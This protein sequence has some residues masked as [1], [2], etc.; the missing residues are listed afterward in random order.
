VNFYQQIELHVHIFSVMVTM[1]RVMQSSTKTAR[2][3]LS[4]SL[5]DANSPACCAWNKTSDTYTTPDTR[6]H[7]AVHFITEL[8]CPLSFVKAPHRLFAGLHPEAMGHEPSQKLQP[9]I[10]LMTEFPVSVHR[11]SQHLDCCSV[12]PGRTDKLIII[13]VAAVS[14]Q[15]EI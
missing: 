7:V 6:V 1:E 4:G 3:S 8:H 10:H 15:Q 11:E 12:N 9:F 14:H 2:I 5:Q 13:V